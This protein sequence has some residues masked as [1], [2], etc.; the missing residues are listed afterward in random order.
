M[1]VDAS[2]R[3]QLRFTVQPERTRCCCLTGLLGG[4][5]FQIR[6]LRIMGRSLSLPEEKHPSLT[7]IARNW[8]LSLSL[9]VFAGLRLVAR[10]KLFIKL[11]RWS[12]ICSRSIGVSY[13]TTTT[14]GLM[15]E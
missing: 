12:L 7:G 3:V 5:V 1:I 6:F 14:I 11:T 4:L 9:R 15:R 13:A 8:A 2:L 10:L